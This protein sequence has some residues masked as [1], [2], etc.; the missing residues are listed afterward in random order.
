MDGRDVMAVRTDV[1]QHTMVSRLVELVR[2]EPGNGPQTLAGVPEWDH[3]LASAGYKLRCVECRLFEPARR[4]LP[5][6]ARRLSRRIDGHAS[7]AD[8]IGPVARE[9]ASGEPLER[10]DPHDENAVTWRIPGPG[11]HVRHYVALELVGGRPAEQKRAV[12][13]GFLV[14]CCEEALA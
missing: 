2:A 7:G 1:V 14:R 4:S 5:E 6:L 10:P 9:L 13:Y 8:A 3:D 12:V 11:G